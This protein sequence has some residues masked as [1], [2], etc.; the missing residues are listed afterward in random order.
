MAQI[1]DDFRIDLDS[2]KGPMDLLLYLVR[3]HEV[4]VVDLPVADVLEQ[5]LEFLEIIEQLDINAVGDFLD[6]ASTL[7]E[8]KSRMVLPRMEEPEGEIDDPRDELVQRLLE[9][10]TFRDA[11]AVLEDQSRVWQ[12]HHIRQTNDL[13]TRKVDV[14]QQ[15]IQDVELWDLVSA[16]G[17]I[18]KDIEVEKPET[19]VFDDTPLHVY[20]TQMHRRIVRDGH[21]SLSEFFQMGMH[22]S[23]LI[24]MFLSILELV[25]HHGVHAHQDGV[26]GDIWLE[27]GE[28]FREDIDLS[29]VDQYDGK[30]VVSEDMPTKMR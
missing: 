4:A 29:N 28:M 18:L 25:R 9:Y 2:F 12:N 26:G 1:A 6:L 17:R 30:R 10:K 5:Y 23:A 24:G 3:K 20:L 27:R 16:M 11:A 15:P 19:I 22:T 8:I 7:T 13:P 14:A 21:V